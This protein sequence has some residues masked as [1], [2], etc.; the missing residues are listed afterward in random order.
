MISNACAPPDYTVCC[1]V[2]LWRHRAD[3]QDMIWQ[4]RWMEF[5]RP[6]TDRAHSAISMRA[7][8]IFRWCEMPMPFAALRQ[9]G[10]YVDYRVENSRQRAG[11]AI[12]V[13]D[14]A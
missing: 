3:I 7:R 5:G 13:P 4:R 2:V 8:R 9:R 14:R 10:Q 11:H 1:Q 6:V 12:T